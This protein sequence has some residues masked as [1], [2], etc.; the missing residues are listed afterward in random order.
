MFERPGTLYL[1]VKADSVSA[2]NL[3]TGEP[4]PR[5]PAGRV[6]AALNY[7][8]D[9]WNVKLET[10]HTAAQTRVPA[11][12]NPSDGYTLWNAYSSYKLNLGGTRVLAW[13]KATNLTNRDARLATS[14]L[15]NTLPLG[16]RA[17][18]AGIRVDF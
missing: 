14:V 7:A 17:L 9:G 12:D 15:R 13:V 11:G 5:I 1:E 8:A 2:T 3:A 4:L 6:G 16:G 10:T 18:Q